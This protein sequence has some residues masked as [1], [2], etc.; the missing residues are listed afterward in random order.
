MLLWDKP[1]VIEGLVT[2]RD[3]TRH[4]LFYVLP[5]QPRFRIDDSG[6]PV[7]KFLKYRNPID[8]PG[9]RKGG[10]FLIFDVELTVPDD[11]REKVRAKLQEGIEQQFAGTGI[12]AP[13]VQIGI[14]SYTRGAANLQFLDSGGALVEKIQSPA[15]PSLYGKMI[16]PFTVELSPEGAALAESALQDKGGVVQVSYDLFT[17]VKMPPV[18]ATVWFHAE[19]FMQFHQEVDVDWKFWGEDDYRETIS[20]QF[21]SSECGGVEIQPGAVTDQKVLGAVRDWA[22]TSLEEAVKRMVLGDIAPV[23]AD[24][25]KVPDGIEN[26]WRDV[27]VQKVASFRRTYKEGQVMD[28]NPAPRGTLPNITS[29]VG[30]DGQPYQWKDFARTVDLDDPFFRSLDVTVRANADFDALPIHSVEVHLEYQQGDTHRIGELSFQKADDVAKFQSFVENDVWKYKRWYEVNY[31]GSARTFKS[32]VIETDERILT[33]NVDDTGVLQVDVLAGDLNFNQVAQAQVT[34]SYEDQANGVEPVEQVFTLDKAHTSHRFQKLIFQPRRNP[35][36]YRVKYFMADGKELQTEPQD[37]RAR[38]LS[39]NDPFSASRT[40]AVRAAGNLD[41][42]I[43]TIFVDLSYVDEAN[44]YTQTQ[45]VALSKASPFFDWQF[46]VIS[47]NGGK[48]VYSGVVQFKDGTSQDVPET[49]ATKNTIRVGKEV[50]DFL[51]V[52]IRPDLIDWSQVKLVK[53]SLRYTDAA[54]GID[55]PKDFILKNGTP[56]PT[57]KL[58]VKDKTRMQ[59][60]WQATFFLANGGGNRQTAA[61]ITAEPTIVLELPA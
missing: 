14:L 18:E 35:Y 19:K 44:G 9:G 8:R 28:W 31:K 32:P 57:W 43:A 36:R 22:W 25:R 5:N 42:D 7:F 13:Q 54:N 38:Q 61:V 55:E 37:G 2:Y 53:V 17:P 33:V 52:E 23:S 59:Y 4:H 49:I 21:R 39:I 48:V 3:E 29:L 46:P 6:L 45:S 51:E 58:E 30:R 56:A 41:T 40:I 50:A 34:L 10:G 20:E 27:T 16:T 12:P 11:Q 26:V 60:R 47:E 24:D 1:D 15:A